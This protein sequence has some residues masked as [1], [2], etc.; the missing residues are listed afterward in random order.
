MRDITVIREVRG[1]RV[2]CVD[3]VIRVI[4]VNGLARVITVWIGLLE[5]FE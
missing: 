1:I 4:R 3:R 2:T 5:L